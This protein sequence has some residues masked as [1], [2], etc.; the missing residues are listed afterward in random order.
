[1]IFA[2]LRRLSDDSPQ[3]WSDQERVVARFLAIAGGFWTLSDD[4]CVGAKGDGPFPVS[5]SEFPVVF[6]RVPSSFSTFLEFFEVST[7]S[8]CAI[9]VSFQPVSAGQRGVRE[10]ACPM[11]GM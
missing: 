3:V 1:V 11:P 2:R 10:Q 4:Y 8:E 9:F 5:F 7:A 6:T